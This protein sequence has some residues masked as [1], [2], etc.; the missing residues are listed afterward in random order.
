MTRYS[1]RMGSLCSQVLYVHTIYQKWFPMITGTWYC[2]QNFQIVIGF[3]HFYLKKLGNGNELEVGEGRGELSWLETALN[4]K[5]VNPALNGVWPG[6]VNQSILGN[7]T[8]STW[9][10]SV[11]WLRQSNNIWITQLFVSFI[12]EPIEQIELNRSQSIWLCL[13]WHGN[14]TQSNTI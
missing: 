7:W 14:E 8:Q 11:D 3:P 4:V 13:T 5:L 1:V 10:Q 6:I 2:Y 12:S 9:T